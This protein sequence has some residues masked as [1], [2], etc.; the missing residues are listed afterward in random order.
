MLSFYSKKKKENY[1]SNEWKSF[2]MYLK[3]RAK[4][5]NDTRM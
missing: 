3:I 4:S 2:F 1:K 5:E